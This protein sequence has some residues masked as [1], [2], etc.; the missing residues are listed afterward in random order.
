MVR[1]FVNEK[2]YSDLP[3]PRCLSDGIILSFTNQLA[4]PEYVNELRYV[5]NTTVVVVKIPIIEVENDDK[6]ELYAIFHNDKLY[7]DDVFDK[8][9]LR[10]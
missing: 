8:F 9:C 10:D 2:F 4:M 5:N 7:Y 6:V 3:C 1:V